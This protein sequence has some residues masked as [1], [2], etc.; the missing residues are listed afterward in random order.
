MLLY[1]KKLRLQ[2]YLLKG[3]YKSINKCNGCKKDFNSYPD[4]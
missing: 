2:L 4:F 1:E 3:D